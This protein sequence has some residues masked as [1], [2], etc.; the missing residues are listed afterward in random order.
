MQVAAIDEYLS[1]HFNTIVKP[2]INKKSLEDGKKI[3]RKTAIESVR[4]RLKS[5]YF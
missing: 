5:Q 2:A 4:D 1:K 3:D